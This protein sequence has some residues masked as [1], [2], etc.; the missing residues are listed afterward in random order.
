MAKFLLNK[1]PE[2]DQLISRMSESYPE[3]DPVN[4]HAHIWL[5]LVGSTVEGALEQFCAPYDIS[6]GRYLMM[7]ILEFRSEGAKPSELAEQLG[8]TQATVTGL[9]D[10]LER[11]GFAR[12]KEHSKD[13]RAC[14]AHLTEKGRKF[15]AKVRPEI[16]KK[17]Q[18]LY[19]SVSDAD[20][21]QLIVLL[22]KVFRSCK[23]ALDN[24]KPTKA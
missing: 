3:V 15:V 10:G 24:P 20:K 13:K 9:L 22:E 14:V 5:R 11:S 23:D 18:N 4:L 8:V 17:I 7:T 12:R 1:L 21:S 16:N 2:K 19:A 6:P